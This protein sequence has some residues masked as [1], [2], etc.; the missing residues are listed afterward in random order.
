MSDLQIALTTAF[1]TTALIALLGKVSWGWLV[2]RLK[3]SLQKEHTEFLDRLQW[4]RKTQE[5]A[6]R[7]A[8]YLSLAVTLKADSPIDDYRRANRL[9]WELAMWLPEEIYKDMTKAVVEPGKEKNAL[10]IVIAV[11]KHLL[12]DKAGSLYSEQVAVHGP[13]LANRR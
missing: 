9:C 10:T 13:G 2:E 3:A 7:V 6:E 12:G 8:E 11:R 1:S 4:E 5:R